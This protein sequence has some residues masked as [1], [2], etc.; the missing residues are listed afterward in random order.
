MVIR[1]ICAVLMLL[2]A[3]L[4]GYAAVTAAWGPSVGVCYAVD[5]SAVETTFLNGGGMF[6]PI[7]TGATIEQLEDGFAVTHQVRF[8]DVGRRV[9]LPD[10]RKQP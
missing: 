10:V 2:L 1:L 7:E 8:V 9:Y 3:M 5:G 4:G 6:Y